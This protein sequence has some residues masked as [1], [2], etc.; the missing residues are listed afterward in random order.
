MIDKTENLAKS[1]AK[2]PVPQ[3]SQFDHRFVMRARR[4]ARSDGL[5]R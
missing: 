5:D 3:C 1:S 2:K 4:F